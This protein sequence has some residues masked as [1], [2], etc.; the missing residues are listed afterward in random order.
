MEEKR[1]FEKVSNGLITRVE[2][3]D[4]ILLHDCGVTPGADE[5]ARSIQLK[6]CGLRFR[7]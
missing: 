2:S 1:R 7:H 6:V 5:D 4:V 3:G